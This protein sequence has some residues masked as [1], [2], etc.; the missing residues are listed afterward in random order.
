MAKRKTTGSKSTGA[1]SGLAAKTAG[2]PAKSAKSA[3]S[4]GS[5]KNTAK[6]AGSRKSGAAA[7]ES[8][9]QQ[10]QPMIVSPE[11]RIRMIAEAAYYNS[12]NNGGSNEIEN[13][14]QAEAQI[15][16]QVRTSP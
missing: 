14:L 9:N 11:E 8:G 1:K 2:R 16:Q 13:W 15:D 3:K 12:I 5:R 4:A 6:P 7:A 10:Q